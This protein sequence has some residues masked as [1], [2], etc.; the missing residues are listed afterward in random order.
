[1]SELK[2]PVKLFITVGAFLIIS[3][4]TSFTGITISNSITSKVEEGR[5]VLNKIKKVENPTLNEI[6]EFMKVTLP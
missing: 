5:R 1:M 6:N 3:V 2:I 4:F